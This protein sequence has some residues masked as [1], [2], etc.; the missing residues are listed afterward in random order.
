MEESSIKSVGPDTFQTDVIEKSENLPVFVLFWAEQVE[1]SV[2][3]RNLL[4]SLIQQYQGKAELVLSDVS[5]DQS[6]A[7]TLRVQGLPSIRVIFKGKIVEQ[8]DGP[9]EEA[10]L[11]GILE[12]LTQSPSDVLKGQLSG[13]LEEKDWDS[14]LALIKQAIEQEPNNQGFRVELADLLVRKGDTDE[15]GKVLATIPDDAENVKRPRTRL[16]FLEESSAIP[17]A[18]ELHQ[19]EIT[20]SN[21][22]EIAY[23]RAVWLTMEE[24][25]QEALDLCLEILSTDREFRDD[26]GRLTMIRIFDLMDKGDEM[27]SVYRRKMF[28]LMH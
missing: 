13:F 4:A 3:M 12:T 18:D 8:I 21:K 1:P 11:K 19:T 9:T 25:Y 15:A 6:L 14:A 5:Q 22:L 24:H 17:S 27:A 26:I 28:N 23:G 2:Q 16:E 20:E 7:Q 10:H